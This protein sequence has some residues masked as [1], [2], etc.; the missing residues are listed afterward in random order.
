MLTLFFASEP[1]RDFAS[2]TACDTS[3]FSKFHGGMLSRG[4]YLPPAQFEAFFLSNAHSESDIQETVNAAGE[5]FRSM[6]S[7]SR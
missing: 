7:E 3:E 1:V 4:I 5:V 2:A 6:K